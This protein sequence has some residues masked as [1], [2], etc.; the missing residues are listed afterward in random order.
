MA[1]RPQGRTPFA[2]LS[3]LQRLYCYNLQGDRKAVHERGLTFM[4]D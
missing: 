1:V 3:G 2:L 4:A